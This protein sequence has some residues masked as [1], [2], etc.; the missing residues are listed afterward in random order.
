MLSLRIDGSDH[1]PLCASGNALLNQ[2]PQN[3]RN[4]SPLLRSE[5]LELHVERLINIKVHSHF[6]HIGQ[7][8]EQAS[9]AS[10]HGGD[11]PEVEGSGGRTS[12][13]L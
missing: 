10:A 3:L 6:L 8:G 1:Q 4:G 7:S 13:V 5:N 2:L 9:R 11:L 12:G